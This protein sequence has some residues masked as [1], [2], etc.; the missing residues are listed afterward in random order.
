MLGKA[1]SMT[2][3]SSEDKLNRQMMKQR[4]SVAGAPP[5]LSG[6]ETGQMLVGAG[7]AKTVRLWDCSAEVRLGDLPSA[8]T[9]RQPSFQPWIWT[10]SP[11][12]K[13]WE[14]TD[15]IV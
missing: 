6:S 10:A 11:G 1:G 9:V 3:V 7:D 14:W 13:L 12:C 8:H 15:Q 2:R 5:S 4:R